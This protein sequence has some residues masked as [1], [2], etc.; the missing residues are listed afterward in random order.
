M[1]FY[2]FFMV[3]MIFSKRMWKYSSIPPPHRASAIP[4]HLPIPRLICPRIWLNCTAPTGALDCYNEK[5]VTVQE[6]GYNIWYKG[7][8]RLW[9]NLVIIKYN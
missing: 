5:S 4:Y 9:Y 6:T 8:Y 1:V 2:D 7:W 3:F